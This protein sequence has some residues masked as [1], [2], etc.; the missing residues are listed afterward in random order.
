MD[1]KEIDDLLHKISECPKPSSAE[2]NRF[3]DEF[4]LEFT[5]N[6]N[7]I[8]DN[9]LT[10]E[11]TIRVLNEGMVICKKPFKDHLEIFG[12][13]E[14]YYYVDD[15]VKGKVHLSEQAIREIHSLVLLDNPDEKGKYRTVP[16]HIAGSVHAPTNFTKIPA[17]METLMNDYEE[18]KKT[19]HP[20]ERIALFHVRFESIHPFIDGNGR[21]GRLVMNMELMKEGYRP[22][23]IKFEDRERYFKCFDSYHLAGKDPKEITEFIA[24][25]EKEALEKYL[26]IVEQLPE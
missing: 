12:H 11:E 19:M 18:M 20:I 25:Y 10:F 1:F 24:E 16:L 21:T 6:S 4:M 23:D 26:K 22:I 2:E 14:A 9:C 17:K 7:A 15:L 13:R 3:R 5:Y 8:E